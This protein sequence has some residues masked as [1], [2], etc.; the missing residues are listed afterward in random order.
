MP[1]VYH[2]QEEE[3]H[4][5]LKWTNKKRHTHQPARP[6]ASKAW[7]R[8]LTQRLRQTGCNSLMWRHSDQLLS[9][10]LSENCGDLWQAAIPTSPTPPRPRPSQAH[11]AGAGAQDTEGAG[12]TPTSKAHRLPKTSTWWCQGLLKPQLWPLQV[13]IT[14]KAGNIAVE[15]V[16][17]SLWGQKS[18][19]RKTE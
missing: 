15:F 14:Q 8:D 19:A 11:G 12:R 17:R 5:I 6:P 4:N 9:F 1:S 16:G 2:Q 18:H 3:R 13:V 7:L 10:I